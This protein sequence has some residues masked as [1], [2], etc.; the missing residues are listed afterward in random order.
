M[1]IEDPVSLMVPNLA[2]EARWGGSAAT[3][4]ASF[5]DRRVVRVRGFSFFKEEVGIT[6]SALGKFIEPMEEARK[7]YSG[8]DVRP[9]P[10]EENFA[11]AQVNK[12]AN[13]ELLRFDKAADV[14]P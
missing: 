11:Q 13:Q 6:I 14:L 10:W 9:F 7:A 8:W 12:A 3:W 1:H 5:S 2:D 4:A